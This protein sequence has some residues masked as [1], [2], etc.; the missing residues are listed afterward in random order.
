MPQI[1]SIKPQ[2]RKDRY[3]V[4][5]DGNFGFGI[6]SENLIKF[7][8]K[9]NKILTRDQIKKIGQEDLRKKLTDLT[10]NYLSFR[11]RSKE[12]IL[13]YLA[14]KITKLESIK[15]KEAKEASV[16]N[17]I[18]NKLEKIH[19]IDDKEFAR[20]FIE[21]KT[22]FAKKG[23]RL[24]KLEL[25]QKGIKKDVIDD[26]LKDHIDDLKIALAA[27][28]KKTSKWQNL[29]RNAKKRKI[30]EYLTRRGFD[31]ETCQ[32]VFAKLDKKR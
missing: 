26:L 18:I 3:N 25:I 31:F 22:R 1:T 4:F 8:L 17:L 30:F 7:G 10:L 16:V 29:E 2:K 12:E 6:D 23:K 9:V 15:F 21:S 14:K 5:L 20:N 27:V 19:L 28:Q 32:K 13:N 24:I 11:Q